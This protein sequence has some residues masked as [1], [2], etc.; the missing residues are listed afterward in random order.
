MHKVSMIGVVAQYWAS[1]EFP[2]EIFVALE[3]C[4]GMPE[5]S[6]GIACGDVV[7]LLHDMEGGLFFNMAGISE[8]LLNIP[9]RAEAAGALER[10]KASREGTK[11]AHELEMDY[12]LAYPWEFASEVNGSAIEWK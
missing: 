7:N 10:F 6:G 1:L 9:S 11:S 8:L 5:G 2:R 3:D 4:I 12:W